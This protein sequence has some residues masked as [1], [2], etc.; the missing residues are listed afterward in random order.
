[1]LVVHGEEDKG[2]V[3]GGRMRE[4]VKRMLEGEGVA[5]WKGKG[6]N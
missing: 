5:E 2:S 4:G 3:G 1:M 6:R